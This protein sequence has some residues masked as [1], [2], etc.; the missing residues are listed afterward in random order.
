MTIDLSKYQI[1]EGTYYDARTPK[2]IID[3]LEKSRR[4]RQRVR[5]HYGDT[6]TGRDWLEGYD[7]EGC[8]GRSMGPVKVPLLIHNNRSL[9]G[10]EILDHCIVKLRSTGKHGGILYQHANYH[11]GTIA[12][13]PCHLELPGGR[14]LTCAVLVN[15]Q[16]HARFETNEQARRWVAKITG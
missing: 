8:I 7:V 3:V 16:E 13:E 1:V 10:P 4:H 5:L 11:T 9:G 14:I 6:E 15:G 2:P 12:F